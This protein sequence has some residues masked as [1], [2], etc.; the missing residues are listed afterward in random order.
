MIKLGKIALLGALFVSGGA[1]AC[2]GEVAEKNEAPTAVG[3]SKQGITIFSA[4]PVKGLTGMFV[5]GKSVLL[6]ETKRHVEVNPPADWDSFDSE[7]T[8]VSVSARITDAEGRAIYTALAADVQPEGWQEE[9]PVGPL[10]TA[11]LEER[12]HLFE[13]AGRA[14]EAL[15]RFEVAAI[16]GPEKRMVV[17]IAKLTATPPSAEQFP[18]ATTTPVV[19]TTATGDVAQAY[20]GFREFYESRQSVAHQCT[21]WQ[22]QYKDSAGK[23]WQYNWV[24][25]INH[26]TRACGSESSVFCNGITPARSSSSTF[27]TTS[28][29]CD[30][31]KDCNSL[32]GDG[33]GS[34]SGAGCLVSDYCLLGAWCHNCRT[35]SE[36]QRK[37]VWNRTDARSSNCGAAA[38]GWAACSGG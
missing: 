29:Y 3:T 5:E 26:G 20:Y 15:A 30:Q 2:L 25:N 13:V 12:A 36:V 9:Q 14:G 35:D 4:D 11:F 27:R 34:C 18:S 24:D 1:L 6:F 17:D 38:A 16:V 19:D 21:R 7:G 31:S 33:C 32:S 37:W 23:W 28:K 8:P 10:T 22:N